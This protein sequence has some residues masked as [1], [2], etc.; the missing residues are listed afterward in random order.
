[1]GGLCWAEGFRWLRSRP[2]IIM[3]SATAFA[4]SVLGFTSLGEGLRNI[5]DHYSIN[6][7]FLLSKKMIYVLGGVALATVYVVNTTGADPWIKQIANQYD[8]S[9]AYSYLEDLNSM[10]GRRAG[11]EDGFTAAE[12]IISN[13]EENELD[14]GYAKN[15]YQ[16]EIDTK[17]V[18][19]LDQ[20]I[21]NIYS[22]FW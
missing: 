15:Q 2:Y 12:Y 3:S 13:F 6:T 5:M 7:S 9:Q 4:L 1:M 18:D 14:P 17:I 8:G 21:L 19:L 16:M 10:N 20:P 22:K 11:T